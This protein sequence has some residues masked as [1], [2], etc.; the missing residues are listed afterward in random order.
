LSAVSRRSRG[1]S[2]LFVA[3]A[4]LV[5]LVVPLVG[6]AFANHAIDAGPE[7]Q[8]V[9]QGNQVTITVPDATNNFEMDFEIDCISNCAGATYTIGAASTAGGPI[10][11]PDAPT[12]GDQTPQ[13]ADDTRTTPEMSCT[14][15]GGTGCS[16][17]YTRNNSG[18]DYVAAW[19]DNDKSN[20]TDESDPT[21]L[22]PADITASTSDDGADTEPDDTDVVDVNWGQVLPGN[23]K[24]DCDDDG[25][26]GDRPGEATSD[27]QNVAQGGN[28]TWTC[29]LWNDNGAGGG[30]LNN[31][32][33]DGSEPGIAGVP[34]DVEI[35]GPNDPDN[36]NF[37]AG[38]NATVD[39][40]NAC[41]T[42]SNGGCTYNA[43]QTEN[44]LG[45]NA[46]YCFW[47]D[48]DNDSQFAIGGTPQDG[49]QCGEGVF[50]NDGDNITDVVT[51]NWITGGTP[52]SVDAEPEY[53]IVIKGG[54][55]ALDILV[56]DGTGAPVPNSPVDVFIGGGSRNAAQGLVCD[57]KLTGANGHVSCNY[58]DSNAVIPIGTTATDIVYA[59]TSTGAGNQCPQ[60][61]AVDDPE[62]DD[63]EDAVQVNFYNTAPSVDTL[64]GD[65]NADS[66]YPPGQ[67]NG[68][69]E[70]TDTMSVNGINVLCG[71]Y[72]VSGGNLPNPSPGVPVSFTITCGPGNFFEDLNENAAN[73]SGEKNLGST[74]T[75][76]GNNTNDAYALF[77]S[78]TAGTTTIEIK[79]GSQTVTVTKTIQGQPPRKIACEPDTVETQSGTSRTFTCTVTDRFAQPSTGAIVGLIESGPGGPGTTNNCRSFD[80]LGFPTIPANYTQ[81]AVTNSAG[82]AAFTVSSSPEEEGAETLIFEIVRW[83]SAAGCGGGAGSNN[84]G[85]ADNPGTGDPAS[86]IDDPCDQG[87]GR[88]S[89]EE[90]APSDNSP[91]GSSSNPA[92]AGNCEDT[93]VNTWAQPDVACDD[94][95]DNDGDGFIDFPDDPGCTSDTD[96]SEEPFNVP[97]PTTTRHARKVGISFDHQ[98]GQ[99]VVTGRLRVPDGFVR[100]SRHMTVEVQQRLNGRWVT[101]TS[102]TTSR[103]GRYKAALEDLAGRYRAVA[104]KDRLTNAGSNTVDVCLKAT[105]SDS[106]HHRG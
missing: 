37:G 105:K 77:T 44:E 94:G 41:T 69:Y 36:L 46:D 5:A 32:I 13:N 1:L 65:A 84:C 38:G 40:N 55:V 100:C 58:T 15:A 93:S 22:P 86:D 101:Q 96:D 66:D 45:N 28:I 102:D 78:T 79:A 92:P 89:T 27:S 70:A 42:D 60:A 97:E 80:I 53:Q 39:V 49:S 25:I 31:G 61:D 50:A 63:T 23:A 8:N 90:G 6:T 18:V 24:L 34:L 51:V 83:P 95:V 87:E 75:V 35:Q 76:N 104:P 73:D 52:T 82:Q 30:T 9:T 33:K 26:A 59:C 54:A 12:D 85:D 99:L 106:H 64:S 4:T 72:T 57:N 91:A 16:V 3:L 67:C 81:C 103:S 56:L 47:A 48:S 71:R 74:V 19:H 10:S 62:Q 68:A 14:T 2:A 88:L 7:P 20:A 11:A 98:R 17:T 43:T 29:L 21:E